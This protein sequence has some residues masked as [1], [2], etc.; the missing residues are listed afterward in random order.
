MAQS[1]DIQTAISTINNLYNEI[2][3]NG[4]ETDMAAL[5]KQEKKAVPPNGDFVTDQETLKSFWQSVMVK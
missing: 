4:D 2:I 1:T 5:Y 3:K